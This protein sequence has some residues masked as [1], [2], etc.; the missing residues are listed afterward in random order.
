M[1]TKILLLITV[2]SA[3]ISCN[4]YKV[5][6]PVNN[7]QQNKPD[8]GIDFKKEDGAL[9]LVQYNV[10]TFSKYMPNSTEMIAD[11]LNEMQ[12]DVCSL[13]ET[14][15]CNTRHNVYQVE[16]LC[17]ALGTGWDYTFAKAMNY[18]EGA[19][20]NGVVVKAPVVNKFYINLPKSSGSEPR[21]ASGVETE[22]YVYVSTH[23]DHKSSEAALKQLAV[24]SETLKSMYGSGNKAVFVAGDF[25]MIPTNPV[26]SEFMKD[27][28]M[29][30]VDD[31][32]FDS[33]V[34]TKCIDYVFAMNN[35]AKYEVVK[36]EVPVSFSDGNV[37]TA[38]DHLPVYVDVKLK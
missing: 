26:F 32:T 19:Y 15:S 29:I 10:G 5:Q 27:F 1:K 4:P 24:L 3:V 8:S 36:S 6:I 34:P 12:A 18:R 20:G 28:R 13:N 17:K 37:T 21:S 14:D 16:E 23:L 11:M 33:Q 31:Y 30:S 25:N 2:V 22:K 9:R 7:G 35:G 38:S